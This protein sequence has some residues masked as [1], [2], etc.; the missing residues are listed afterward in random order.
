M[1]SMLKK[2]ETFLVKG[3]EKLDKQK[4][5]KTE[6]LAHMMQKKLILQNNLDLIKINILKFEKSILKY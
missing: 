2:Y 4:I 3:I 5:T 6:Y 1:I